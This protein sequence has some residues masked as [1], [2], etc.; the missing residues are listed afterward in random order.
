MHA[1]PVRHGPTHTRNQHNTPTPPEANHL[2]RHRLCS[3]KHPRNIDLQQPVR[4]GGRVIQ[5]GG[6]L[7]H[8]G[9]GNKPIKSAVR[10]CYV[11]DYGVEGCRVTHVD[12]TVVQGRREGGF[13]AVLH[14][15]EMRVLFYIT[16]L[17]PG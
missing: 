3:H 8:T 12:A 2:P 5:R 11:L 10:C 6:F 17:E 16:R 9:R 1:Y 14:F 15:V 4:V 13:G 7:L